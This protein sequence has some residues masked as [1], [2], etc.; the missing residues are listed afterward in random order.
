MPLGDVALPLW[1]SDEVTAA[2]VAGRA[3]AD[4]RE[5]ERVDVDELED[6]VAVAL[7]LWNRDDDGLDA[8]VKTGE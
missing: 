7:H 6:E 5:V 2:I 3:A 8:E 1:P 4:V